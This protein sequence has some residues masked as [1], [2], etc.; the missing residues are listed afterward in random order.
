LSSITNWEL[1][2]F[3]EPILFINR[4]IFIL[5]CFWVTIVTLIRWKKIDYKLRIFGFSP[6]LIVSFMLTFVYWGPPTIIINVKYTGDLDQIYVG[7]STDYGAVG[8]YPVKRNKTETLSD[9]KGGPRDIWLQW[10]PSLSE[11][12]TKEK[13]FKL[14]N[15]IPVIG[16]DRIVNIE[17][18]NQDAI[19]KVHIKK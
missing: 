11:D 13:V 10:S 3:W 9:G 17:I 6:F 2:V 12:L 7:M 8:N 18:N 5:L 16:R 4:I 14:K 19:A 15:K 1:F